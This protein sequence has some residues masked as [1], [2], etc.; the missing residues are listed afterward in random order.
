MGKVCRI[1][2]P[3]IPPPEPSKEKPRFLFRKDA[4][5][6]PHNDFTLVLCF[7]RRWCCQPF[8]EAFNKLEIPLDRCHLL[9]FCNKDNPLLIRAL[10]ERAKLYAPAFKS[11]RLY[12]SYRRSLGTRKAREH[13]EEHRGKLPYIYAMYMDIIKMVETKVMLV[14]EDDSPP[15][16]NAVMRLLGHMKAHKNR[17]FVTGIETNRGPYEDIK[18][19]LGVHYI[20]RKKNKILERISLDPNTKGVVPVDACGWYCCASTPKIWL[21]GF[22]GL[23]EYF[24]KI[25]RFALDMFH[26]NNIKR[27]GIPVIADF[28]IWS[29]HLEPRP[30]KIIFWGKKQAVIMADYW[31]DKYKVYSQGIIL[32]RE[33]YEEQQKRLA[34]RT[35]YE[36]STQRTTKEIRKI[37]KRTDKI[38]AGL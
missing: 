15:S 9:I 37:I 7:S 17:V 26:T 11:V 1:G 20:V 38:A 22:K 35:Y 21:D 34:F 29:Y 31:I 18:T 32:S 2:L 14:M 10:E 4:K 12:C 33:K 28:D 23:D 16:S 25:P 6:D 36:Q 13:T 30:D 8:F 5:V 3:P 27:Q 19:R 24:H